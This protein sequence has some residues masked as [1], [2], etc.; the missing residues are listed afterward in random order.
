MNKT[1][2]AVA[3]FLTLCTTGAA[4]ETHADTISAT[5]IAPSDAGAREATP[6]NDG[7][8]ADAATDGADDGAMDAGADA[9]DGAGQIV[10]S[11]AV[12]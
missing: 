7:A 3:A 8:A 5:A 1:T 11:T 6:A 9:R 12:F 2:L 4:C 10:T